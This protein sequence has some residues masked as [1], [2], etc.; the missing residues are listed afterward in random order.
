MLL[1]ADWRVTL[2]PWPRPDAVGVWGRKPVS[3]R[4][5]KAAAWL[6]LPVLTIEDAFLR[7]VGSGTGEPVAG[8]LLDDLGVHYDCSGPSRIEVLL[9]DAANF[10]ADLLDRAQAGIGFLRENG[11]SKYN[12]APRG[13]GVLPER[14]YVLVADQLRG[15]AAVAYGWADAAS[16]RRMLDAAFAENPGKTVLIRRHPDRRKPGH[17]EDA[18]ETGSLRFMAAGLNPWD[19]LAGAERVY[20]VTSQLG[21][22]A[23]LAGHRPRVFG[24]PFYAGWGLS[25]DEMRVDRR[26]RRVSV[27][28][29]FAATMM[30]APVWHDAVSGKV[31]D[32]VPAARAL[33]ARAQA[34]GKV[35]RHMVML[36]A[37]R[38]KRRFLRRFFGRV[39]FAGSADA[40]IRL[41]RLSGGCV[42]VWAAKETATLAASCK[43]Y[44]VPLV[45]VED[46]FL[47]SVGL[48]AELHAPASLVLDR[49][50]IYFDP[51][52]PSDL[53]DLIRAAV[54]LSRNDLFRA[55]QLRE[56]ICAA[57]VSKYNVGSGTVPKVP[58]G[59]RVILVPGQVEDDASIRLGCTSVRT[60]SE[61]LRV[62]RQANPDAFI[63]Y[64]PHPDVEA[65]LRVGRL[66]DQEAGLADLVV[67]GVAAPVVIALADEVWTMT[68]LLGFEAL[69]RAKRVVTFGVP[70][71][72]GWGLTEDRGGN[73]D[74]RGVNVPLDGLVHAALIGYPIYRDPGSGIAASPEQIVDLLASVPRRQSRRALPLRWLN[75]LS[76]VRDLF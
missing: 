64:K 72:A 52:R 61:L 13:A 12:D 20:C 16:F 4:G 54:S 71:Y 33:L 31:C 23:I 18:V 39:V 60:N 17:F 44:G 59:R 69:L 49:K 30:L 57:G 63:L 62:T 29:L 65:G 3:W 14:G 74:R 32:F 51:G 53:E 67:A 66:S 22:E 48:G 47:R 41:A 73:C 76:W 19:A 25:D 75:R 46:G 21:F 70:F 27:A 8:L 6:G 56:K 7:S 11:L 55:R 2:L 10:D 15:D 40:A 1:T 36:G 34:Q 45:R 42:A 26:G 5:L 50:G 38:W 35:P 37:S 28:E 58:P 9:A 24:L 68:S 43:D